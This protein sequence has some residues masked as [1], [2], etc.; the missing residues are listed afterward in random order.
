MAEKHVKIH[1][2]GCPFEIIRSAEKMGLFLKTLIKRVG[3]R[4]LGTHVYDIKESLESMGLEP[5]PEEPEG[6][7]A[8]GVLSTSHAA[9]CTYPHR[10]Y[11][12]LDLY[13]C[14]DFDSENV[15]KAVKEEL[16]ALKIVF[17]DL[18]HSLADLDELPIIYPPMQEVVNI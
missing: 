6:I 8:V 12:V 9:I 3:M 14:S 13:S 4:S 7:S 2:F 11:A 17:F 1:A 16:Q 18:S 10:G 5:Y 15:K